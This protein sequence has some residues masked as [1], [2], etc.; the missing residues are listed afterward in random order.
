MYVNH[1]NFLQSVAF[2]PKKNL[3]RLSDDQLHWDGN[4]RHH[5]GL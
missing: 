4:V 1:V 2:L 3:C 5:V